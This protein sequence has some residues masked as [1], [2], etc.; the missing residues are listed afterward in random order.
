MGVTQYWREKN[1]TLDEKCEL[2]VKN[3]C[4]KK[5]ELYYQSVMKIENAVKKIEKIQSHERKR[6]SVIKERRKAEKA[7]KEKTK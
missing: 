3:N 1:N 5:K 4:K 2:N 7:L 6:D